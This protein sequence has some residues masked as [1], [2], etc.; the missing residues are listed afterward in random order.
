MHPRSRL[1]KRSCLFDFKYKNRP[2]AKKQKS[3]LKTT[4]EKLFKNKRRKL[5]Y[6]FLIFIVIMLLIP[7]AT[8][9][10]FA[11]DLKSKDSIMNRQQTGLTLMDRDRAGILHL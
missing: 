2:P 6:V 5:L 3:G 1:K 7:P 8:Y 4:F 11:K 10:Y 9:L